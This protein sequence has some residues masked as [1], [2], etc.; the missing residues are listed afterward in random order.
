MKLNQIAILCSAIGFAF[1]MLA[2]CLQYLILPRVPADVSWSREEAEAYSAAAMDY[3]AKSFDKS[4]SET[5]LA[6]TASEYRA[7]RDKLD[8]AI[9]H[10]TNL[11]KYVQYTGFGF[12]VIGAALYIAD[13]VRSED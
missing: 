10:R 3:H 11:P 8:A 1:V 9:A 6:E 2:M 13:K 7:H 5:E 4:V 12:V